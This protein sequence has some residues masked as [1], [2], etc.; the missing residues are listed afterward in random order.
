MHIIR[1][2]KSVLAVLALSACADLTAM[3]PSDEPP[4]P[5]P[6]A[7]LQDQMFLATALDRIDSELDV[8]ARARAKG[9]RPAVIQYAGLVTDHRTALSDELSALAQENGVTTERK[10]AELAAQYVPLSADT[11]ERDYL[12]AEIQYQQNDV[13]SFRF[14][15]QTSANPKLRDFAADQLPT[16]EQD[17]AT[18]QK[19]VVALP[20]Q[21]PTHQMTIPDML[22]PSTSTKPPP[23][24]P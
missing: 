19:I 20:V 1:I 23:T 15:A 12:D 14:E 8:S 17:L 5:P 7:G 2:A 11:F 4:P 13:K 3:L 9:A 10:V 18:A 21:Q 6:S 16:L 22:E 24:Q